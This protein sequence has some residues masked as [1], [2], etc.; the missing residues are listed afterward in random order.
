MVC[1]DHFSMSSSTSSSGGEGGGLA[2]WQVVV[3]AVGVSVA[4]AGT[5]GAVLWLCSKG[6]SKK[7]S[8]PEADSRVNSLTSETGSTGHNE[9]KEPVS[10]MIIMILIIITCKLG[11]IIY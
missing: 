1:I 11:P 7:G 4:V 5:V 10:I 6:G 2:K 8:K 9:D 3:A